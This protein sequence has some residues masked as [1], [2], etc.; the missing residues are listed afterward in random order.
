MKFHWAIVAF[1]SIPNTCYEAVRF[2]V[3][4]RLTATKL[5]QLLHRPFQNDPGGGGNT[6]WSGRKPQ[7][8][9]CWADLLTSVVNSVCSQFHHQ[10]WRVE[11]FVKFSGVWFRTSYCRASCYCIKNI[12][13]IKKVISFK[14]KVFLA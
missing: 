4:W 3:N 9:S 6:I 5:C 7:S 1:F 8:F 10:Y 11:K 13:C 14:L 12:F 2:R